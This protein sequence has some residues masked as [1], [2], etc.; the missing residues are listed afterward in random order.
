MSFYVLFTVKIKIVSEIRKHPFNAKG[1]YYVNQ[2]YCTW[3]AA[4]VDAAPQNF[5][6]EETN[7]ELG[8]Y[9]FGAYVFKQPENSE[10][11]DRC[12]EAFCCC[13]HEAIH[14]DGK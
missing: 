2:D 6:L 10:E 12:D 5:K 8:P 11:E 9:D 1:K 3:C 13:P 7:T 4:C 14:N